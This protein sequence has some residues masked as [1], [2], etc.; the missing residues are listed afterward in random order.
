MPSVHIGPIRLPA[1][2]VDLNGINRGTGADKECLPPL[3][4][5]GQT[6]GAL[7]NFEHPDG[8]TLLIVYIYLTAGDVNVTCRVADDGGTAPLDG[9]FGNQLVIGWER[10]NI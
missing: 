2:L 4:S 10:A 7:R 1:R 9:E 3:S 8:T 5:E 6:A